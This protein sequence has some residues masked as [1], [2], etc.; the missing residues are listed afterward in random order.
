MLAQK[1]IVEEQQRSGQLVPEENTGKMRVRKPS[2]QTETDSSKR[3]RVEELANDARMDTPATVLSPS[4][5][6]EAEGPTGEEGKFIT[7]AE[8]EPPQ[9]V[10]SKSEAP[11]SSQGATTES[12][13]ETRLGIAVNE[14]S[15]PASK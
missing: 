6:E 9:D 3:Q 10:T 15:S 1:L 4:T 8:A 14:R 5:H 13:S 2:Q 11:L 7:D 12:K